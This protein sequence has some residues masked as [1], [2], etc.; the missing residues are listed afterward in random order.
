[1]LPW[2]EKKTWFW[3]VNKRRSKG[4]MPTVVIMGFSLLPLGGACFLTNVRPQNIFS[5]VPQKLREDTVWKTRVS[6]WAFFHDDELETS[7]KFSTKLR[8][9]WG[10]PWSV[11]GWCVCLVAHSCCKLSTWEAVAEGL[12]V[13]LRGLSYM[14]KCCFIRGKWI[15][16]K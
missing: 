13:Y 10:E 12:L 7:W 2:A 15:V 3:G 5:R 9:V 4:R 11:L 6:L 8:V 14:L 1:M 16:Y